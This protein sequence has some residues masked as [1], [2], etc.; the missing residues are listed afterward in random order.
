MVHFGPK[1]AKDSRLVNA[2]NW[3]K[4]VQK[5][6]KWLAMV[7]FYH[8]VPFWVHLNPFGPF[9]TRMNFLTQRNKGGFG[10]GAPEQKI[11]FF[12]EMVQKNPDMS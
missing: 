7:F 1:V 8:L 10:G 6:P 5:G 3:S 4:R 11:N 2:P 12:F 9:Q